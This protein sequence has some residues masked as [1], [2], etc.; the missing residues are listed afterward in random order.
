MRGVKLPEHKQG[1]LYFLLQ[2]YA[3]E[4]IATQKKVVRICNEVGGEH[5]M[6]LFE[7]LTRSKSVTAE[8]VAQRYYISAKQLYLYRK[9]FSEAW[10]KK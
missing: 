9:R 2:N 6:A 7:L 5:A 3:D 4:P 1:R 8:Q 10:Y